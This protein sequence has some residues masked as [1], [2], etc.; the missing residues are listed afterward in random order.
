MISDGGGIRGLSSLEILNRIMY[1]VGRQMNPPR[2][3]LEPWQ[4]F[5]LIGGTSTGG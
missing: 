5:D 1:R 4:Y 2:P 3:D